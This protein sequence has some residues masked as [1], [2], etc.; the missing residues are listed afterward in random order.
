MAQDPFRYFRIEARQ[1]LDGLAKGLLDLERRADAELTGRLLRLAHTLK[2]AARIV[3]HRELT[4]LAHQMEDVLAPLREQ[5]A[6]QRLDGGLALV[7]QMAVCVAALELPA[8]AAPAL[9]A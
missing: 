9:V 8:P 5:P 7:D 2:G 4:E 6:P 1:L 3:G